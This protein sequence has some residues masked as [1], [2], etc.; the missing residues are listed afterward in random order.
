MTEIKCLGEAYC[1][2]EC[3]AMGCAKER[4]KADALARRPGEPLS[5]RE[6]LELIAEGDDATLYADDARCILTALG[7]E[8]EASSLRVCPRCGAK[9]GMNLRATEAGCIFCAD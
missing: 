7:E 5:L 6:R 2:S 3:R 4:A 1:R 9:Q 8:D